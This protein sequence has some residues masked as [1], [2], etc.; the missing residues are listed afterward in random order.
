M[1]S[2]LAR[3]AATLGLVFGVW[4]VSIGFA[5]AFGAF[6]PPHEALPAF[7]GAP[8]TGALI[9]KGF[10][11]FVVAVALGTLAEISFSVRRLRRDEPCPDDQPK[12]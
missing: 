12:P 3:I 10:V 8:T 6:G 4:Q 7:S 11:K 9:D 2:N 5:V 1:F